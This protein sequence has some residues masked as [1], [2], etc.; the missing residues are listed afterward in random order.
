MP[1]IMKF[2][3]EK[4]KLKM[5]ISIED[6]IKLF[7]ENPWNNMGGEPFAIVRPEKKEEFVKAFLAAL[8]EESDLAKVPVWGLSFEKACETILESCADFLKY[9]DE[10]EEI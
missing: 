9:H 2:K 4:N 10:K 1:D 6:I 7:E 3:L 8:Q 5:E